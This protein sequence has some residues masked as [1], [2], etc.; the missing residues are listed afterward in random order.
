MTEDP[1][2]EVLR[3]G[4]GRPRKLDHDRIA[5][6]VIA[7]GFRGLTVNA[8]AARLGVGPATLYRYVPTRPEL[9]ALGFQHVLS[10]VSWPPRDRPW[11]PLLAEHATTLW[12]CF[13]AHPGVVSEVSQGPIPAAMVALYDDLA[14]A[15]AVQGFSAPNA[16]L[17]VD[18]V[19]DLTIDHR[20][21]VERLDLVTADQQVLRDSLTATWTAPSSPDSGLAARTQVR[22]AMTDAIA[23]PPLEWFTR[24]LDLVL[25]GIGQRLTPR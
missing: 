23:A 5:R 20:L 17:A 22:Q 9:L 1:G 7:E 4:A 18:S 19:I 14:V 8:V 12:H 10:Q 6:A 13:A 25:A 16:V 2:P 3:R 15:L 21:G 24:K 11:Q